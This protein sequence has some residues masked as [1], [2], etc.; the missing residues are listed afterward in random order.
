MG[1]ARA[2]RG[3][4]AAGPLRH[5]GSK[6]AALL[7][8][9]GICFPLAALGKRQYTIDPKTGKKLIAAQEAYQ[10]GQFTEAQKILRSFRIDKLNAKLRELEDRTSQSAADPAPAASE[11]ESTA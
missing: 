6:L 1:E 9:V 8:L 7:L 4:R 2:R 3:R 5:W 10:A 11:D